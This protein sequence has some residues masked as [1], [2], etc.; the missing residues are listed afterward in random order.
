MAG[1]SDR[2]GQKAGRAAVKAG[3]KRKVRPDLPPVPVRTELSAAE[4]EEAARHAE[5][6]VRQHP[7]WQEHLAEKKK[8][9]S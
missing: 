5:E 9:P 1:T 7:E 2:D 8:G 4:L 6:L 3:R